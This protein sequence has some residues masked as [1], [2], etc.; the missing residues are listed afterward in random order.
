[1]NDTVKIGIMPQS[2]FE[3]SSSST[4]SSGTT[5]SYDFGVAKTAPQLNAAVY[6]AV[7]AYIQAVRTLGRTTINTEEIAKA[8]SLANAEV[9]RVVE[10]MKNRGV[11]RVA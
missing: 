8:L 7:Y 3:V 6:D 1:M 10:G 2:T 5:R 4:S 9:E 11:R